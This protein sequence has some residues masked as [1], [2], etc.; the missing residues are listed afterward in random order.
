LPTHVGVELSFMGFLCGG[1]AAAL[2]RERGNAWP[3]GKTGEIGESGRYRELQAGFL[4]EHLNDW[5]PQ[6]S[7]VIQTNTRSPLYRGL[8]VLTEEFLALDSAYLSGEPRPRHED[9]DPPG[10]TSAQT[11]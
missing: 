8:A 10:S 4:Q 5:F 6:L 9:Q 2:S 7:K 11:E 3:S 1:E